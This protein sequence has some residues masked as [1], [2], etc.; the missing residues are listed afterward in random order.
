M[1]TNSGSGWL[2]PTSSGK[3]AENA[4]ERPTRNAPI[5]HPSKRSPPPKTPPSTLC[6][7]LLLPLGK[8]DLTVTCNACKHRHSSR[9]AS[10][11]KHLKSIYATN[12]KQNDH[13]HSFLLL[14]VCPVLA[15]RHT[16]SLE[17]RAMESEALLYQAGRYAQP[18]DTDK[19]CH[20]LSCRCGGEKVFMT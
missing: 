12:L 3:A 7:L 5:R 6:W 19:L 13:F 20:S 16:V 11:R 4:P 10:I 1:G 15:G 14:T 17:S 8:S 2:T 18:A 9:V